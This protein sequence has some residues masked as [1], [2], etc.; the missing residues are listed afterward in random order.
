[1][2]AVVGT[3]GTCPACLT[4]TAYVTVELPAFVGLSASPAGGLSLNQSGTASATVTITGING[5]NSSSVNLSATGLPSGVTASFASVNSTTSTIMFSASPTAALTGSG[6][7]T[8]VT[9]TGAASGSASQSTAVNLFVNPPV[10]GGAGTPVD[11][12]SAYNVY[13]FYTDNDESAI[14]GTNSLDGVG[15]VYSENLLNAGLDLNGTQF[16][17]GTPNQA[18]AVYGTGTTIPLPAGNYATLQLLATGIEGNQAS[19]SVTVT[20]TDSTTS[21]FTQSFSDWC[22]ALNGGG[23]DSTGSNSG[24]SLAIAMPYRDSAAGPDNRVFYLYGY[25]FAL[26]GS[27]TVQSMTLPNTRDVVVLAASLTAPASGYSLSAGTANPT[28]LNAGS[29][30]TATVTVTPANG[31]TGSITLSCSISPVVSGTS[32]PTCSLTNPVSVASSAATST[33]TFNT[34]APVAA[35]ANRAASLCVSSEPACNAAHRWKQLSALSIAFPALTL[36]CLGFGRGYGARGS[37]RIKLSGF[38]LLLSMSA[39]MIMLSACGGGSSGGGGGGGGLSGGTP[40]GTY[41]ITIT[42]KDA[43]NVSQTGNPAT[44]TVTVN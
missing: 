29:S 4:Q 31:Y 43:N 37:P 25:S 30:S 10:S 13:S 12:S 3:S 21:Q 6:K 20:Y 35:H 24:E 39:S 23:C 41:T 2:I 38:F 1:M 22:S 14:T 36:I 42:A 5:F 9:I 26:N 33:L 18:N 11:L 44:V 17:L 19:K 27:K 34:V 7:P 40:S 16:T 15:Y 8:A 32:A 28:S